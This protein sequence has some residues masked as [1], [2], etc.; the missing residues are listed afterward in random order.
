MWRAYIAQHKYR[1]VL[2]GIGITDGVL[3]AIKKVAE[4][5]AHPDKRNAII[6]YFDEKFSDDFEDENKPL[7]CISASTIYYNEGLFEN[8]LK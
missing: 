2:D 7:W 6:K 1:V 4:Y 8:S 3:Q 5:F